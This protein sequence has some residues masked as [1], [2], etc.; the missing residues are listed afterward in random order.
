[1]HAR[2]K[3][4][5][6]TERNMKAICGMKG[7][8]CGTELENISGGVLAPPIHLDANVTDIN[9]SLHFN[10]TKQY[11]ARYQLYQTFIHIRI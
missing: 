1:M 4:K 10:I 7:D 5:T 11:Q 2:K 6:R 9:I 8:Y 3:D